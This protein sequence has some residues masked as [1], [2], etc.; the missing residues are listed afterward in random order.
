[1]ATTMRRSNTGGRSHSSR[2]SS[3][4]IA[5]ICGASAIRCA[6]ASARLGQWYT[7]RDHVPVLSFARAHGA[8][9]AKNVVVER[10]FVDVPRTGRE[11]LLFLHLSLLIFAA[12]LSRGR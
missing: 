3:F 1:M 6:L 7:E 5:S 2:I 9:A 8:P 11:R 10:P 4:R 12:H